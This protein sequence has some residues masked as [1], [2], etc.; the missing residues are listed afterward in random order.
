MKTVKEVSQITGVSIRTLRYYDEIGLLKPAKCTEAGYRLYDDKALERLQEILFYRELEIPL[1]EMKR[2]MENPGYNREQALLAQRDLLERK[3]NR[4]DG[5]IALI[6]DVMKG[7][8]TM[9]FEA[10]HD[11]DVKK[12]L[13][14]S[15]ELQDEASREAIL[16][17]FGSME[18][19]ESFCAENL[20]E[21]KTASELIR[22]Y[23]GKEK[24][25]EASLQATGDREA[26]QE[27]QAENDR[28]YRQFARAMEKDDRELAKDAVKKLEENYKA[29]FRL[30]N[31][32][33]LLLQVARDYLNHSMLEAVTD[34]QYGSGVTRYIGQAI[35][36]YYGV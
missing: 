34:S 21:E 5:I 11:D 26:Q 23:G 36:D 12:I 14:H 32:R 22:I 31:A 10:F 19:Y 20:K 28:I 15:L 1:A 3:R 27:Q 13:E 17:E 8:N 2:I 30:E 24:A 7:V 9:S 25:V 18:A 29:M 16:K 33:Y 35:E 6:N 4:L